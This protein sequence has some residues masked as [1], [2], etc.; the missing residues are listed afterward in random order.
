MLILGLQLFLT[1]F[2]VKF[3][4]RKETHPGMRAVTFTIAIGQFLIP[5]G[6]TIGVLYGAFCWADLRLKYSGRGL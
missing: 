5:W 4:M 3:A 2:M 1:F 6:W